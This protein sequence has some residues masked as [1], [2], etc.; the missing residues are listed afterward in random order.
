MSDPLPVLVV[1]AGPTG[2]ALATE[3]RMAGVR[4]RVV[5]RS[6]D[7]PAYQ[8]RA[9]T[10][11]PGALTVLARH[12]IAG[13][14][15]DRGLRLAGASYYSGSRVVASLRFPDAGPV[16]MCIPQPDVEEVQR[17]NLAGRWD[18][19]VEWRTA[20]VEVREHPGGVEA[21]LEGPAGREHVEV[22]WVVGCDGAHSLVRELAGIGFVGSTYPGSYILGDG[23]VAGATSPDEVHY[24]LHSDGV[25]VLVPLP[26]GGLRVFADA[27]AAGWEDPRAPLT[28][29]QL[30]EVVDRRAPYPLCVETLRWSTRF[31]VHQRKVEA[32]RRGRLLLAGDAAHIHSPAG[33]QGMNTGIQDAGNLG[34]RLALVLRGAGPEVLDGYGAERAPVANAVMRAS[35][36]QTRMWNTRSPVGRGVRDAL[37]G[38]LSRTGILRRRV[39]PLL[40][41]DDLDYRGSP[42]VGPRGGRRAIGDRVPDVEVH[43]T[44][45]GPPG[46]LS[47][48][49]AEEPRHVLLLWPGSDP[50]DIGAARVVTAE[51]TGLADRLRVLV[52]VE[53]DVAQAVADLPAMLVP[54]GHRPVADL[55]GCR[56]AL[57]RPD[58][59]LA[60]AVAHLT[61]GTLLDGLRGSRGDSLMETNTT[62][63]R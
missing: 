17:D 45:G 40:A 12:G 47:D 7:R 6:A 39:L 51:A 32:Y 27:T 60:D 30:Q 14:V 62:H 42:S 24:T 49:L 28:V 16:P 9:L 35:H 22:A 2:L 21:V 54:P 56:M 50:D 29:E 31:E 37:L 36:L 26:G 55:A 13:A 25:L 10:M 38:G 63:I 18:T 5:D 48:L 34:W 59:Y 19:A 43:P 1:G 61:T 8:A 3:L 41:Q 58:G 33:G 44:A 23:T 11:W 4:C 15:A 46:R 52:L 53:P 20:L 57:V